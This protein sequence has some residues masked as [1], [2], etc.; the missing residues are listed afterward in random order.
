MK[1]PYMPFWI[2]DYRNSR[3]VRLMTFEQKG[4]YLDMIFELWVDE[5]LPDNER[6][7]ARLFNTNPKT[8]RRLFKKIE[9]RFVKDQGKITHKKVDEQ[10]ELMIAKNKQNSKNAS[11]GWDK[12][13]GGKAPAD[14]PASNPQCN[15]DSYSDTIKSVEVP[16]DDS[17]IPICG[18]HGDNYEVMISPRIINQYS[19]LIKFATQ[20]SENHYYVETAIKSGLLELDLSNALRLAQKKYEIEKT[21]ERFRK[22]VKA[23]FDPDHIRHVLSDKF[24]IRE[25]QAREKDDLTEG[26]QWVQDQI[27]SLPDQEQDLTDSKLNRKQALDLVTSYLERWRYGLKPKLAERWVNALIGK[28]FYGIAKAFDH[29]IMKSEKPFVFDKLLQLAN[30]YN[31]ENR[32]QEQMRKWRKERE[33]GNGENNG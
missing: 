14:A 7:L 6:E 3:A 8:F 22:G 4:L 25:P 21:P 9:E 29:L 32:S 15:T 16:A 24:E 33:N 28:E 30:N 1:N 20:N 13:R 10:R 27:K 23:F 19:E 18:K 5:W 26:Q 31:S 11:K 2:N 12:R 17:V